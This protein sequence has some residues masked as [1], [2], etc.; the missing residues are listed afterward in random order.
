MAHLKQLL[1]WSN[2]TSFGMIMSQRPLMLMLSH[3]GVKVMIELEVG[4]MKSSVYDFLLSLSTADSDVITKRQRQK[5]TNV[6]YISSKSIGRAE[7]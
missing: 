3:V 6:S 2:D 7:R 1:D 5:T 4:E